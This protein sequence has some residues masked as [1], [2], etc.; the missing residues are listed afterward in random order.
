[1]TA[2]ILSQL[3]PGLRLYDRSLKRERL[4]RNVDPRGSIIFLEFHNPATGG[5]E[6]LRVNTDWP[7]TEKITLRRRL[8]ASCHPP[9]TA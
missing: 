4:V 8:L 9:M 7:A 5:S 3:K 6:R 2:S 1:M